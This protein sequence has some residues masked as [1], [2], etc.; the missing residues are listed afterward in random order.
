VGEGIVGRLTRVDAPAGPRACV[1]RTRV[2]FRLHRVP[3]S[4]IVRVV[5]FVNGRRRLVRTG[6]DVRRILLTGLPRK[7]RLRV[8]IVATHSSGARIE[9]TRT[10][11]GCRKGRPTLRHVPGAGS[12]YRAAP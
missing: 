10:W 12:T 5:A 3:G 1:R 8:R 9:S 7:G 2:A 4:R 11:H 6:H